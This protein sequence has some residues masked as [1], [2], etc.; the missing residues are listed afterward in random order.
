MNVQRASIHR[1]RSPLAAGVLGAV[2]LVGT[3]HAATITVNTA[4]DELNGNGE[5][6]LREAIVNANNNNTS[7]STDCAAGEAP[8]VQDEIV[9]DPALD[10][11]AISLSI[12]GTGEEAAMTGDLDITEELIVSGNGS[13]A[14]V[15]DADGIDRVFQAFA[16]TGI[17]DVTVQGGIGVLGAG[18]AGVDTNVAL[19]DCVVRDNEIDGSGSPIMAFGGG[20]IGMVAGALLLQRCT[21]TDNVVREGAAGGGVLMTDEMFLGGATAEI[22]I[23][24]DSRIIGNRVEN[25]TGNG[26]GGGL[27]LSPSLN[28]VE[29]RR[30]EV[31]G[32]SVSAE[33]GEARGGGVLLGD[34]PYELRNTTISGNSVTGNVRAAGGG[35]FVDP[36]FGGGVVP[37][38]FIHNSTIT[39]NRANES[40]GGVAFGGGLAVGSGA[41]TVLVSNTIVAGNDAGGSA[42]DCSGELASLGYVLLGSNAGCSFGP[43]PSASGMGDQVGDVAG[44]GEPIDPMLAP[45]ADNGG[46]TRTHAPIEGSPAIDA[47]NPNPVMAAMPPVCE[48]GDQRGEPRPADGDGDGGAVCDIGAFEGVVAA[49]GGAGGSGGGGMIAPLMLFLLA[50]LALARLLVADRIRAC[51]V[52]LHDASTTIAEA[53]RPA[54]DSEIRNRSGAQ[55]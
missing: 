48:P 9:F 26:G 45:L 38:R 8:P 27:A 46:P 15:I 29:L 54:P 55:R 34:G 51:G 2:V 20:G 11:T 16:I 5:C 37:D 13:A 21:V 42:D 7:G 10:G 52:A 24:V 25:A 40:M 33:G 49:T 47:G 36:T 4:N 31:S 30:T 18:I 44:G 19:V 23:A 41:L 32:N 50:W 22:F 17:R 14:T 3:A 1:A 28:T 35:V 39:D 6:A 12:P 53:V 43:T